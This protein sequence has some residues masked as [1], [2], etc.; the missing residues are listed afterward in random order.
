MA[1]I[2]LELGSN[3]M[4]EVNIDIALG[5]I[6]KVVKLEEI[7]TVYRTEPI[8]RYNGYFYNCV[9]GCKTEHD[10]FDLKKTIIPSIEAKMGR[11]VY[12]NKPDDRTIDIDMLIYD[13]LASEDLAIPHNDIFNK[14]FVAVC[15][16]EIAPDLRIF[17]LYKTACD[18]SSK[19]NK[20]GMIA[21]FKYTNKLR[22]KYL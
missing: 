17:P 10:P 3:I 4:P 12:R 15:L 11:S 1:K 6:Q 19:M 22:I 14:P 21:L 13:D 9:L 20:E 2:Y 16:C 18:I 5:H 8:G 7:S